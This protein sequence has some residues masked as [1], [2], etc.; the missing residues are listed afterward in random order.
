MKYLSIAQK[1]MSDNTKKAIWSGLETFGAAF[2]VTAITLIEPILN[3]GQ[4]PTKELI[5]SAA[6]AGAI[7]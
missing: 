4:F 7:A 1:A 3:A 6:V 2:L 5:I